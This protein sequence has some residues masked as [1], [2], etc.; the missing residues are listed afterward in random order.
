MNQESKELGRLLPCPFCASADVEFRQVGD[1]RRSCIVHCL[2]CGCTLESNENCDMSGRQWNRRAPSKQ[3][4]QTQQALDSAVE[5]LRFYANNYRTLR[6]YDG[7]RTY[8]YTEPNEHVRDDAGKT[9]KAAL[10]SIKGNE[11]DICE[12]LAKEDL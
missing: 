12:Q 8:D 10:D 1:N 5:A 2:D 4:T 6:G 3:L 7:K 9:A 11:M